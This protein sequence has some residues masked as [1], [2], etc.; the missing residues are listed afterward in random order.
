MSYE[1]AMKWNR[2]HPKGTKQTVIMHTN[3]GFTPSLAFL[4]DYFEYR[5]ECEAVKIE[6][7]GCEEYYR[8]KGEA[9]EALRG[10]KRKQPGKQL[11]LIA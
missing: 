5:G 2:R 3:S 1:K 10:A 8:D 11:I 7:I 9:K 4:D 6:P